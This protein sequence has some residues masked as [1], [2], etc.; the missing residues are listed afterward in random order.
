MKQMV[1]PPST[2]TWETVE[3]LSDSLLTLVLVGLDLPH[4]WNAS[5]AEY[6]HWVVVNIPGNRVSAGDV[7]AQYQGPAPGPPPKGK[8]PSFG[9]YN[10]CPLS[11]RF[12]P[13]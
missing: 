9:A 1:V 5:E 6:Q 7:L 12:S 13:Y 10:L 8:A 4:R 2:C 3:Y 11:L